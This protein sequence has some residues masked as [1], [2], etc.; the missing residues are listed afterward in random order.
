[1]SANKTPLQFSH[2]HKT[3]LHYTYTKTSILQIRHTFTNTE[4]HQ[5]MLNNQPT[6]KTNYRFLVAQQSEMS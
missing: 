3:L 1:M 6:G 5:Q 4:K 2:I